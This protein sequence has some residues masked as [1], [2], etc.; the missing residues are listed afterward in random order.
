ML[1]KVF[2]KLICFLFITTFSVADVIS[3]TNEQILKLGKDYPRPI[4]VHEA[5][6]LKALNAFKKI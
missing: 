6:R 2:V 5:A 3:I 1:I 4:V